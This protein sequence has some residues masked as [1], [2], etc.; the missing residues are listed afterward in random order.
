LTEAG[1]IYFHLPYCVHRCSYCAF[2]VTTD[3]E[4]APRYLAALRREMRLV[5]GE[6]AGRPFDAVYFGGGT[7][8]ALEPG[9][10]AALMNSIAGS[11]RL[12]PGA[13]VT[14]E[15][16]PDDVT[17]ALFSAW[18]EAGVTRVSL[19]VQS[20]DDAELRHIERR[21]SADQARRARGEALDAGFEVSCD[22]LLGI[23]FQTAGTFL[24]AVEEMAGSGIGHLSVYLLELDKAKRLARDRRENP[25]RYLTDEMQADAYLRAGE[26]LASAGFEHYEISNWAL[27]GRRARHNAKYWKRVPTLGFGVSA[28]ELWDG[29]RRA[30]TDSLP[31]Y[32]AAIESGR[33][34][35]VLDR[36]IDDL[37]EA[38]ERILLS[39]RTAEGIPAREIELW[40]GSSSDSHLARDWEAWQEEG[41]VER[42]R[43]RYVLTEKGLLLSNEILCR[44]V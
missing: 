31:D 28:H 7:P 2:V 42:R 5:A 34:P 29:R 18:R 24:P 20:L 21:H 9:A 22:L 44:F 33:R 32:L 17:P 1:G 27:P 16:N 6:A 40:I 30:N 43:E 36:V 35:T 12:E 37:E 14:A 15:A 39:A 25:L 4:T 13:E 10:L 3:G 38:R 19:G 11:Y 41:L 23:P 8:S 26:I